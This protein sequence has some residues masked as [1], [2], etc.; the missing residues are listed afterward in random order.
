MRITT[1]RSIARNL[2]VPL[3]DLLTGSPRTQFNGNR[4]EQTVP[5]SIDCSNKTAL[6]W[7]HVQPDHVVSFDHADAELDGIA[8]VQER[9]HRLWWPESQPPWQSTIRQGA[10]W[11][12]NKKQ[13]EERRWI[14]F[15]HESFAGTAFSA[16]VK[17]R[18]MRASFGCGAGLVYRFRD[19][20]PAQYYSYV[21]TRDRQLRFAVSRK[22]GEKEIYRTRSGLVRPGFNKLAIISRGSEFFLYVNDLL[23]ETI[24]DE[25]IRAGGIGIVASGIGE[26]GFRNLTFYREL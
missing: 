21:L 15:R 7:P 10:Y 12:I 8:K 19:G 9:F 14:E 6:R 5:C 16:E 17:C 3:E 25:E 26:F 18:L 1:A 23:L 2:H 24:C 20:R 13:P 22:E 4:D 11:L